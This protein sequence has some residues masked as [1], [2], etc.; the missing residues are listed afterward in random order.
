[1]EL[2]PESS[3]EAFRVNA[4]IEMVV[5]VGMRGESTLCRSPIPFYA[6]Q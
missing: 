3:V 2:I 5:S 4:A 1:M 6:D